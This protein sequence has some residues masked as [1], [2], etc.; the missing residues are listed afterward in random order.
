MSKRKINKF[1]V[2]IVM[3]ALVIFFMTVTG[4]GRFV[5]NTARDRYLSSKKFYF[6]SNLLNPNGNKYAYENWDGEGVY[7]I[8]IELFS[9]QNDLEQYDDDLEYT[10]V[11][12]Y[13]DTDI[14]CSLNDPTGFKE[15]TGGQV[16]DVYENQVIPVNTHN[17]RAKIY[18]KAAPDENGE[19]K[20]LDLGKNHEISVTAY[21]TEPY[22][23]SLSATFGFVINE[24]SYNLEDN[25][26]RSYVIL[27]VRNVSNTASDITI[28]FDSEIVRL[29]INDMV[30]L[31]NT[32]KV[33]VDSEQVIS[34]ITFEM[35]KETSRDIKFYK[36][37]DDNP[38]ISSY[39]I[40]N[41]F[42]VKKVVK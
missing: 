10:F 7:E 39:G 26:G 1:K 21:T 25:E 19:D 27:N 18:I 4:L 24:V 31:E 30:Y 17:D 38:L 36:T 11:I 28:N 41:V 12:N 9:Q 14:L 20:K 35:P 22:R 5:Y 8:D 3:F 33:V 42:E 32:D 13:N 16:M 2:I 34:S 6:T 29:D 37:S 15:S 23:K 40:S